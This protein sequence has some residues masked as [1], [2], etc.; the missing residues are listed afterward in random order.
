MRG[1]WLH[2]IRREYGGGDARFNLPV[3][4]LGRGKIIG[5]IF[6]GVG[7]A[8]MWNPARDVWRA[9]EKW[10]HESASWS[11]LISGMFD[12]PFLVGGGVA[13]AIGLFILAGRCRVEWK[14]GQLRSTE[15][16]GPLRWTRRLPRKAIRK[17]Q[18]GAATSENGNS[19]PREHAN[20][21]GLM[22]EF[23]DGS[24]KLIALGYPKDWLLALAQELRGYVGAE[25]GAAGATVEVVE[26]S[27]TEE[28]ASPDEIVEQPADS[29]IQVLEL[30]SGVQFSVPPAGLWRGSMGMFFFALFWCGFMAV[31]TGFTFFAGSKKSS[32][33]PFAFWIFIPAFWAIGIG[34]LLG[35]INMGRRT[36]KLEADAGRLCVETRGL[37]GIKR[38]EWIRSD[39]SA[40]RAAAGNM[41]V[42]DHPVMELQIHPRSG[43]KL[44]LLAGR[45]ENELRWLAS[46]LRQA[47][48]VPA[49][50]TDS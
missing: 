3:R 45:N 44:G 10:R 24:K 47:L 20:F 40:I 36:A 25:A 16:F 27:L 46:R 48:K 26:K 42:N 21:S 22:A 39:L 43:K 2:E 28:S 14:S 15:I 38:Q 50:S 32:D 7:V 34:L 11:D 30:G 23:A 9:V 8:F 18:V 4:P 29:R 49:R 6:T 1:D 13:L 17:L 5:L 31:F 33:V 37:F 41:K 12:L 35:A 19:P